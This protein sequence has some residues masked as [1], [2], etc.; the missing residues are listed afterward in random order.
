VCTAR[1]KKI[2]AGSADPA[3]NRSGGKEEVA[4]LLKDASELCRELSTR[5]LEIPQRV[6]AMQNRLQT[7][8]SEAAVKWSGTSSP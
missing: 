3:S 2:A 7:H 8:L 4:K 1:P 6:F 5:W